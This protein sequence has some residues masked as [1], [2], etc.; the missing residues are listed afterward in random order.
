MTGTPLGGG[1]GDDRPSAPPIED[2]TPAVAMD[3]WDANLAYAAGVNLS[4]LPVSPVA[5]LLLRGL[6]AVCRRPPTIQPPHYPIQP[7]SKLRTTPPTFYNILLP[8][9]DL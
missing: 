9:A 1:A 4:Q 7:T 3:V 8:N 6:H 5:P 2:A